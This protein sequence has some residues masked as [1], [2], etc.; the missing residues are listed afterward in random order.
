MKSKE[1]AGNLNAE[2]AE[3]TEDELKQAAGGEDEP[4]TCPYGKTC[5]DFDCQMR[6]HGTTCENTHA[7][8]G[9]GGTVP[10]LYCNVFNTYV[11]SGSVIDVVR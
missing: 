6:N 5:V 11:T 2:F 1:E 8:N 10:R 4:V 9:L 3:L 7:Q